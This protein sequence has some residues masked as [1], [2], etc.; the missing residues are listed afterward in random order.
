MHYYYL[1]AQNQPRGPA[2]EDELRELAQ[3]GIVHERTLIAAVGST[4]WVPITTVLAEFPAVRPMAASN[5][6]YEP[7]AIWSLCLGFPGILCCQMLLAP[8]AVICGHL[9]L[10]AIRRNPHLEGRSMALAG[11]ICGYIGIAILIVMLF[12]SKVQF[13]VR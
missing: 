12:T 8:A 7:L 13:H 3:A 9:A 10:N 11:L 4:D 6:P 1:S 5:R 2:T